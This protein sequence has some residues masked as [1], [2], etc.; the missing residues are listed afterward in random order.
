M[1]ASGWYRVKL[2]GVW[3]FSYFTCGLWLFHDEVYGK[4]DDELDEIN[5]T[6]VSP[7]PDIQRGSVDFGIKLNNDPYLQTR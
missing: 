3:Y 4:T 6:Q 5:E 7:E 1:R 2:N